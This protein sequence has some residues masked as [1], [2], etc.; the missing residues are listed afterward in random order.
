MT[1]SAALFRTYSA[2]PKK[3]F[4]PSR[5]SVLSSTTLPAY[6]PE[7][8]VGAV[9]P[10]MGDRRQRIVRRGR[11]MGE[12]NGT[13][14]RLADRGEVE[15]EP[16]ILCDRPLVEGREFH[17]QVVRMLPIVQRRALVGFP[18]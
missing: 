4:V 3:V 5:S 9:L 1:S 17:E 13:H 6:D 18:R 8:D 7:R 14:R 16:K 15:R 11:P 12:G 10:V 2:R